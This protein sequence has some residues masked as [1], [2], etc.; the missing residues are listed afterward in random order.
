MNK[1]E[2][3]AELNTS[4]AAI[5]EEC[6]VLRAELDFKAKLNNLVRQKPHAWLSGAAAIG[7][8]LAGPKTKT[9][10]VTKVAKP[11]GATVKVERPKARIGFLALLLGLIRFAIP[12][13]RPALSA[14]AGKRFADMVAKGAK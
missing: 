1:E 6:A 8:F 5:V 3:L 10:V 14:Y 7:W 13:V 4:R 12:V 2:I 9:R 11:N